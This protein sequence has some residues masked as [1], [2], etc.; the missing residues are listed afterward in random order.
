MAVG[1]AYNSGDGT[2]YAAYWNSTDG[3][4]NL[5]AMIVNPT[6]NPKFTEVCQINEHSE[7]VVAGRN[8]IL[9][10]L[11]PTEQTKVDAEALRT[12][13]D[14]DGTILKMTASFSRSPIE[15]VLESSPDM[16]DWSEVTN[17]EPI[18]APENSYLYT[19]PNSENLFFRILG[20]FD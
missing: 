7:I 5:N 9:Y 10:L 19:L 12:R 15:T 17:L 11:T 20:K 3:V 18:E 6:G 2:Y 13:I 4:V 8:G 14:L 1:R 16:F